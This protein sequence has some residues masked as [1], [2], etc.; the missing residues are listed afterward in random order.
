M[1]R[2]IQKDTGEEVALKAIQL[3]DKLK[4][5]KEQRNILLEICIPRKL[6]LPGTVK[7][8]GFRFPLTDE[9]KKRKKSFQ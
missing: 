5:Q 9:Q 3:T 2:A 6:N 7:F 4:Q 8:L 1:F